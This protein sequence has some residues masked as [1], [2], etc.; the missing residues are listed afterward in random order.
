MLMI[1]MATKWYYV[2]RSRPRMTKVEALVDCVAIGGYIWVIYTL[3]H[4]AI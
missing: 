2:D 1:N 4:A 3:A